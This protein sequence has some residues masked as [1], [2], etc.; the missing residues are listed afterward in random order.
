[1]KRVSIER[2]RRELG[3]LADEV[4]Q[5]GQDVVLTR[6]GKTIARIVPGL[7]GTPTVRPT[8]DLDSLVGSVR[9]NSRSPSSRSRSGN[10]AESGV[11]ASVIGTDD[12][13]PTA[14]IDTAPL[15]AYLSATTRPLGRHAHRAFDR[16]RRN[17]ERFAVPSVCLFEVGQLEERG[18]ITLR[19]TFDDWCDRLECTTGLVV[20]ALERHHVSEARGLPNRRDPFDRLI[21]GTAIALRL[22]LITPDARDIESRRVRVLW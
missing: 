14:V 10:S 12:R 21:A 5:T 16:A 7:P 20:I 22:P 18:R 3:R 6:R 19:M 11:R 8:H 9:L 17:I 4:N 13:R 2:A 1:M 15:L